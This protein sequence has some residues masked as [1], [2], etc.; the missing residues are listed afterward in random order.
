[1]LVYLVS[2]S[3]GSG[4]T[5]LSRRLVGKDNVWDLERGRTQQPTTYLDVLINA[6]LSLQVTR[7]AIDGLATPEELRVFRDLLHKDEV[8]HFHVV[9]GN[10]EIEQGTDMR[11]LATLADY[12]VEWRRYHG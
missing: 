2:G 7:M 9:N 8:T 1:M 5:L 12:A 10:Q 3:P 6:L 11:T 4:R